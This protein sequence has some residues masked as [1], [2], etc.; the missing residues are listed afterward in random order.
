MVHMDIDVADTGIRHIGSIL[1]ELL[2]RY[3]LGSTQV[4][5]CRIHPPA[6]GSRVDERVGE[7]ELEML[8]VGDSS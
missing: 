3:A 8:I 7:S 6:G 1:N 2:A 5:P 4:Q